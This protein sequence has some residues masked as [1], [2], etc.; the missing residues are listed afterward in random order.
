MGLWRTIGVNRVGPVEGIGEALRKTSPFAEVP[1]DGIY[2]IDSVDRITPRRAQSLS[3]RDRGQFTTG[4]FSRARAAQTAWSRRIDSDYRFGATR[5]WFRRDS[6]SD[7][8]DACL[9]PHDGGTGFGAGAIYRRAVLGPHGML[10]STRK[11][12]LADMSV[13]LHAYQAE[14]LHREKLISLGTLAA[15]LMRHHLAR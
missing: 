6:V 1:A 13:R 8:Q 2:A 15:G 10:P 5:R 11:V 4:W 12:V 7:R 14:A 3:S 9:F